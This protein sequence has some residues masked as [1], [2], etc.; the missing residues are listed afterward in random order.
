MV[1]YRIEARKYITAAKERL[2]TSDDEHLRYAAG[3]HS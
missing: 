3:A 1:D 2:A